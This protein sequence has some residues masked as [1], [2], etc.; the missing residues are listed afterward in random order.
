MTGL[1]E[2]VEPAS[3][4][5]VGASASPEKAGYVLL[6]NVLDHR[7]PGRIY[8]INPSASEILG[9]RA[10]RSVADLPEPADLVFI[11]VPRALVLE[12]VKRCADRGVK[13]TV[14]VTAGFGEV[15]GEG[16]ALEADLRTLLE[17]TGIRAI[18]PNTVGL[19][20]TGAGLVAS[21]V[22]FPRWHDGPVAL[23]AQSGVFVGGL[24][25]E[26][27]AAETQRIGIRLAVA[28]G[29]KI[30]LDE[31]DFVEYAAATPEIRVIALHME[32]LRRPRP[33]LELVRQVSR[34]KPVI[35][36]K[37][38]R[39]G[40][41][42][43]AAASHTGALALEDPVLDGALRQAN[44]VR[45]RDATE[46]LT[47]IRAFSRA[48]VPSGPRVGVITF[49]GAWGV[50]ASDEIEEAGLSLAPFGEATVRRIDGVMP[51]WQPVGNPADVWVA[52][53]SG[54]RRTLE[55]PLLALLA[56]PSVDIVLGL[57]LALPTTN[58]GEIADVFASA[59]ARH[60]SKPVFLTITGGDVKPEW[61]RALE[62]VGLV[63]ENDL[64]VLVRSIGAMVE[65]ERRRRR[66]AG[67]LPSG[68]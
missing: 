7:F 34:D 20:N 47:L 57:L 33:F 17:Q 9:L 64:R 32:S 36:L 39:T 48:P 40:L 26:L 30:D 41:G 50:M 5:I 53:G 44:A 67:R 15:G 37:T 49:S 58:F 12:T 60:P 11:S 8:P 54:P 16:T 62:P 38:G 3:I 45:A 42:A 28:F 43:R 51:G 21:F 1:R 6:R 46:F 68:C 63:I 25:D 24:A 55:E 65:Y 31:V 59:R 4:A 29:N 13:G 61:L 14:I 18:G 23:A 22:P 10:Y 27:M 66:R 52:L 35:V 56:D 2:L 19:V